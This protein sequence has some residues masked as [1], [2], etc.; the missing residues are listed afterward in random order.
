MVDSLTLAPFRA[1]HELSEP[2]STDKILDL[3]LQLEAFFNIILVVSIIL[4]I[5]VTVPLE[6]I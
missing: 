2:S 4:A 1:C 6:G 5:F 3:F